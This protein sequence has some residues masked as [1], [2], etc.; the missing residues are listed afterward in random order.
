MRRSRDDATR[1]DTAASLHLTSRQL[2]FSL[3]LLVVAAALVYNWTAGAGEVT[4]SSAAPSATGPAMQTAGNGGTRGTNGTVESGTSAL[5]ANPFST[6]QQAP[7]GD[8]VPAA[9]PAPPPAAPFVFVG[10]RIE[11][12]RPVVVLSQL[13]RQV[14]VHGV[15]A[16]DAQYEVESLDERQVVLL[17]LPLMTRQALSLTPAVPHLGEAQAL[18]EN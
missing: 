10:K 3:A 13:G 18:E 7:V 9:A 4:P 6:F 14:A 17:Y 11:G 16:L 5:M 1:G 15:G 8:P 12:G 2:G